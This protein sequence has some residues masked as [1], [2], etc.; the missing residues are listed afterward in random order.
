[1]NMPNTDMKEM[2]Q[3]DNFAPQ[4]GEMPG[5]NFA[6]QDNGMQNQDFAPQDDNGGDFG[7]A[8]RAA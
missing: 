1:M 8:V 2:P 5:G 3:D 7:K 4:N 6:P